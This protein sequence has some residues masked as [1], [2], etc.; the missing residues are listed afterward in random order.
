MKTNKN[1]SP[2]LEEY[3][4][5]FDFLHSQIGKLEW[6]KATIFLGKNAILESDIERLEIQ[7]ENYRENIVILLERVRDEVGAINHSK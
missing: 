7:I 1:Y 2:A 3:K 4:K 5:E 6:E